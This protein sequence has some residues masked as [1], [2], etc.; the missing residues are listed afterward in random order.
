MVFFLP[1]RYNKR[2]VRKE[3]VLRQEKMREA[4]VHFKKELTKLREK[5]EIKSLDEVSIQELE[6]KRGAK[7]QEEEFD[8]TPSIEDLIEFKKRKITPY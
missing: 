1:R 5:E 8:L 7:K 3:D 6:E 4:E 2:E